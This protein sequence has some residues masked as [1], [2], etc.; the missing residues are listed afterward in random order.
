MSLNS[1][2]MSFGSGSSAAIAGMIVYQESEHSP[3]QNYNIVGYIAI[4]A[5]LL[6]LVMV[7][8]MSKASAK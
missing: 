5:T 7:R 4:A 2:V 8:R 6:A 3:L 1:A